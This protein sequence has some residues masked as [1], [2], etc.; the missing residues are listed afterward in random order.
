[1]TKPSPQA[2][3]TA[4]PARDWLVRQGSRLNHALWIGRAMTLGVRAVVLDARGVFLV[5][6]TY[7]SGWYLPGGGVDPGESAEA[8]AVRELREEGGLLCRGRPVLHGFYRNGRRDHVAC[9]V[10]RQFD[11]VQEGPDAQWEIAE[12]GFFAPDALP[13]DATP[14]TRARLREVLEGAAVAETW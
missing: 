7:L 12:T 9:Y 4:R 11:V 6:H 8:A 1:M 10:V 13:A 14:A 5:R 3:R 2:S